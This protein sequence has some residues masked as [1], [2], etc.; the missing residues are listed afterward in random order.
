MVA[1]E[2]G[3]SE[4]GCSGLEE[5]ARGWKRVETGGRGERWLKRKVKKNTG[6]VERTEEE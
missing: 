3:G 5:G 1:E 4:G 2:R 6:G